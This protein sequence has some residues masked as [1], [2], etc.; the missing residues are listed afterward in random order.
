MNFDLRFP[1]G[2][3]FSIFGIILVIY[4]KVSNPAVYQK[5]SLG[6]NVNLDWGIVL[7]IFGLFM[8]FLAFR[9]KKNRKN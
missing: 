6:I 7:L 5:H 3:I 1:L 4:G 2:I 8:L 9:S